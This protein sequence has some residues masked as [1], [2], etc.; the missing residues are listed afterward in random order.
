[1]YQLG[2]NDLSNS[3]ALSQCKTTD[4]IVIISNTELQ[5]LFNYLFIRE[6]L[7]HQ[8]VLIDILKRNLQQK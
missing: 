7:I 5:F 2:K 4:C 3:M 6:V 8:S 1:M